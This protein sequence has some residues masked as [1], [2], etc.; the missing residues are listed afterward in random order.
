MVACIAIRI[1]ALLAFA[2]IRMLGLG[3][4]I[5]EVRSTAEGRFRIYSPPGADTAIYPS[6]VQP[7]EFVRRPLLNR[8]SCRFDGGG[9]A[10]V[11]VYTQL[12]TL[13]QRLLWL[14]FAHPSHPD[15]LGT[16]PFDRIPTPTTLADSPAEFRAYRTPFTDPAPALRAASCTLP[17]VPC[18][19]GLVTGGENLEFPN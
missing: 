18:G 8:R 12:T 2:G 6:H 17:R 11:C 5:G 15:E 4:Y 13:L 10:C 3:S 19:G 9:G 16:G 14:V 7:Y 1:Y